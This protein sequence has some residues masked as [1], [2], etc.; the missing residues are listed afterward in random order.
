MRYIWLLF[1]LT[2]RFYLLTSALRGYKYSLRRF[3]GGVARL[4]VRTLKAAEFID[5]GPDGIEKCANLIKSG[6]LVAFPTETVYGL[7]ANALD[8]AAV[9]SIFK[10]KAR[11]HTDPLIVHVHDKNSI[12][13]LFLFNGDSDNKAKRVCEA[14]SDEFWPGPLTLVHKASEK[15]SCFELHTN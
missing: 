8:I 10:A 14:L 12:H 4:S 1:V 15:V 5:A 13:D 9:E 2:M 3:S 6:G 7:G 11:P